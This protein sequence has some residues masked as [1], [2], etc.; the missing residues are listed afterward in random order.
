VLFRSGASWCKTPVAGG[1]EFLSI[2]VDHELMP[3]AVYVT[4]FP[5]SEEGD[6]ERWNIVWGR[7][8]GGNVAGIA[9]T[10]ATAGTLEQGRDD[11]IPF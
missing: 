6:G 10:M 3:Q 1:A 4:A 5:P 7:P 11:E 2:T 9:H 8:R